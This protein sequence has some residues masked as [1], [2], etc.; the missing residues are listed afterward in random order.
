MLVSETIEKYELQ[1]GDQSELST[2]ETTALFNKVCRKIAMTHTWVW[3]QKSASVTIA[4]TEASLASDYA[5]ILETYDDANGAPNAM[6]HVT[7]DGGTS[8]SRVFV[9]PFNQRRMYKD[10]KSACYVDITNSKIVFMTSE[11]SGQVMEIDYVYSPATLILTDVIPFPQG[12][13]DAIPHLMAVEFNIIE[14]GEKGMSYSGEN[15]GMYREY[16]SDMIYQ[17]DL[18][19]TYGSRI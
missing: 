2:V 6:A 13:V 11:Y 3:L 19:L 9:I 15:L 7:P 10:N 1:V 17:N 5:Y 4:G 18:H 14:Q 12:I 16:L 8:Y